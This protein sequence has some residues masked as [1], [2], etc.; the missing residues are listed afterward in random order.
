[1]GIDACKNGCLTTPLPL[2]LLL[3]TLFHDI[4][5]AFCFSRITLISFFF[6]QL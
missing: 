6:F 2:L 1:M 4:W 5:H 3:A